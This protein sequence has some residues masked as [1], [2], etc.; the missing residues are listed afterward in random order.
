M[1]GRTLSPHPH[2]YP[3]PNQSVWL[4]IATFGSDQL[5]QRVAWSLLQ[6]VVLGEAGSIT[7]TISEPYLAYYD[8]MVRH[9]LGDFH[10]LLREVAYSP[11]M[12]G[13][14]TFLGNKGYVAGGTYPDE[15]FAREIMQLYSIGLW[16]LHMDGTRQLDAAG[17]PI[18]TYDNDDIMDV[19]RSEAR[20]QTS[21]P[22]L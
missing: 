17:H 21:R 12:A 16:M 14:L 3:Y 19:S 7:A 22:T 9:A 10:A 5:R 11:L 6:I 20:T 4:E 18:P 8:M 2:P 15:N 1:L 13:Y